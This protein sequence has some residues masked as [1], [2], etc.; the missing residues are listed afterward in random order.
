MS[1]DLRTFTISARFRKMFWNLDNRDAQVRRVSAFILIALLG[2]G[3][4]SVRELE[5]LQVTYELTGFLSKN[6]QALVDDANLKRRYKFGENPLM[7]VVA[8][9]SGGWLTSTAVKDLRESSESMQAMSGVV[10]A[11]SLG[12]LETV[13]PTK[14]D[15]AVKPLADVFSSG[16][17]TQLSE[18]DSAVSPALVSKD[19]KW[20]TVLLEMNPLSADQFQALRLQA[21]S[22]LR[23]LAGVETVHTTGVSVVQAEMSERLSNELRS[24]GGLGIGF[25][26]L[27]LFILFSGFT[28]VAIALATCVISIVTVLAAMS[29][30]GKSLGVLSLSLPIVIAVQSLS[31]TVHCLFTYLEDRAT[32]ARHQALLNSF[33]RLLF[34][35]FVVSLATG[36]GFLTLASSNVDAMKE[37]GV[38]VAL[39][40]VVLWVT[41]TLTAF[42]LLAILPEP[43][44]RRWVGGR[45]QWV[46][47]IMKNRKATLVGF[48]ILILLTLTTGFQMNYSHRLF[49]E[50]GENSRVSQ[51]AAIVDTQMGGLIPLEIE[52]ATP[53]ESA[54]TETPNRERL[55]KTMAL[56]R[57][58]EIVGSAVS[59]LDVAQ[60]AQSKGAGFGEV[61]TLFEV[62]PV[63]PIKKFLRNDGTR[64]RISLRLRDFESHLFEAEAA[65]LLD[66]VHR[67]SHADSSKTVR[68]G[69][70]AYIHRMNQ[71]LSQSLV[72]GF[73]EALLAISLVLTV[74]FRSP[75]WAL[76]A[77]IPSVLPPLLLV[78]VLSIFK[79]EIKPGLAVVFA[80]ALGFAFINSIYLL[81][82]VRETARLEN[83][84]VVTAK[85]IER[86]FWRESQSCLLA[87]LTLII[88][89][90]SLCFSDFSVARS[91][92]MAMVFS[93]LAGVVGDLVLLPA[94]LRQFP[95]FLNGPA[96]PALQLQT[97]QVSIGRAAIVVFLFLASFATPASASGANSTSP[98][99]VESLEEFAKAAS[100][101]LFAKD[102]SVEIELKN[103][104]TDGEEEVR[105]IELSRMTV[106]KGSKVEQRIV[107]KILSPKSLRGT[108][109]LTITDGESQNR[110]IYL[111]SSKQVR[112][113]VGSDESSAP[114]LGSELS[115]EDLDLSQVDGATAKIVQRSGGTVTIESKINSKDSAYSGCKAEFDE[116][117]RLMKTA[118]C[119]DRNGQ[120]LKRITVKSYRR[121]KGGIARPTEMEVL[122]LKSKRMTRITFM[123]QRL[124]SG[125]KTSR[126]TPEALR[127]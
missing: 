110:W 43:R 87:S 109:V 40:S 45:A 27:A 4:V 61:L 121:L 47:W 49:D 10:S 112:R 67:E 50:F 123:E 125:L 68:G 9:R 66:I 29:F 65:R 25:A 111:P 46:L 119:S 44:L 104:E 70:G 73:W 101:T 59:A 99:S 76:A 90:A 28:G 64:T 21:E 94:L 82:R 85:V 58:Q 14:R 69:W 79:V 103:I 115:T 102:E 11:T 34:P 107:A 13:V 91:F 117:S 33:R 124:N 114:I 6:D 100:K 71:S 17:W 2:L 81:K 31:L 63:N 41:T 89:F 18:T 92:G 118:Q 1:N 15:L 37:F 77:V 127:D 93:M 26:I 95:N 42:P 62:A 88:G 83:S 60:L 84:G 5:H 23:S 36:L 97:P 105:R 113:V 32:A 35:N 22:Q 30:F 16:E 39:A 8:K 20:A 57:Q 55:A 12:T 7:M 122:N 78:A 96:L 80:I 106:K 19:G 74:V 48:G 98:A 24:L 56:L 126:F 53:D 3:L 108:S 75:R 72:Q 51:A 86:A 54:W 38:I 52:I 120:P 116:K